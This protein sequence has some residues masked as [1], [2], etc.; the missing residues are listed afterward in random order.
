MKGTLRVKDTVRVKDILE[1]KD[2]FKSRKHS[3]FKAVERMKEKRFH[4]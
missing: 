4:S 2:T 1:V 3:W